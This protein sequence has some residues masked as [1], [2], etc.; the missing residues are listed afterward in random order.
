MT[1]EGGPASSDV[2]WFA[3][4]LDRAADGGAT[5]APP[6]WPRAR[7][8]IASPRSTPGYPAPLPTNRRSRVLDLASPAAILSAQRPRGW[9]SLVARRAH[10]PEVAGSN[11]APATH[12]RRGCRPR[13]PLLFCPWGP[14]GGQLRAKPPPRARWTNPPVRKT[15]RAAQRL[16]EAPDSWLPPELGAP[17]GAS[18]TTADRRTRRSR[19]SGGH[20]RRRTD[21]ARPGSGHQPCRSS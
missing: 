20:L 2:D 16:Q 1:R 5:C 13:R 7:R 12:R 4:V 8:R 9:G 15:R 6:W 21:R 3:S 11:P 19:S 10:N 18:L 17:V 14:F